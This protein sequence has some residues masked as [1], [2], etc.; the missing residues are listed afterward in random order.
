M[1]QYDNGMETRKQIL[2]ACQNLFYNKGYRETALGDICREAHVNRGSVYYHFKDKE[3]IRYEVLWEWTN[4]C[5]QEAEKYCDQKSYVFLLGMFILWHR[6]FC[7][8]KLQKFMVE[9]Y[10]DYPV[11]TPKGSICQYY[12]ICYTHM[13]ESFLPLAQVDPLALA[14]VYGYFVGIARLIQ[15]Q[16]VSCDTV[17]M[18]HHCVT[19][20]CKIWSI[21][22]DSAQELWQTL[23]AYISNFPLDTTQKI[24]LY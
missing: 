14:S 7:D 12:R 13:Y 18:F 1:K 9:Y 15:E 17:E 24:P 10:S 20:G 19:C 5:V 6:V 4:R 16:S 11:Y 22:D 21:P 2:Q 3:N 8:T 23:K